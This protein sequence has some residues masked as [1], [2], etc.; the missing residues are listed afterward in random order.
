[1]IFLIQPKRIGGFP[2]S[3]QKRAARR[4][5]S[6]HDG[7]G[8]IAA[9]SQ[10]LGNY[11]SEMS[12]FYR[13]V[14]EASRYR[15]TT[16][17][18]EAKADPAPP[19]NKSAVL[20]STPEVESHE[21]DAAEAPAQWQIIEE[22]WFGPAPA[23]QSGPIGVHTQI[24]VD[25]KMPLLSRASD[26]VVVEFYRRLRTKIIQQQAVKPFRSLIVTSPNPQEGK[27]LTAMN[28]WDLIFAMLPSFKVLMVDGDLRRGSLSRGLGLGDQPGFSDLIDGSAETGGRGLQ[29]RRLPDERSAPGKVTDSPRRV[30][31]FRTA[32][33]ALP[34]DD[35]EHFQLVVG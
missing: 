3:L 31:P 25:K 1:M 14:E 8:C 9:L 11:C 34:P 17:L 18:P 4:F 2:G 13:A 28:S 23:R 22:E 16:D 7:F 19:D 26:S 32:A 5:R 24:A 35:A 20:Q 12:R 30:T 27:T 10:S 33:H 29:W 15:Q 6:A 21:P